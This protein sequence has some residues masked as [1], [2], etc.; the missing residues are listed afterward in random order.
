MPLALTP[1]D[2]R[3][4]ADALRAAEHSVKHYMDENYNQ[5]QHKI[6]RAEYDSLYEFCQTL[7]CLSNDATTAAVGLSLDAL[8]VPV[9]ELKGVIEEANQK[10]KTLTKI[11]SVMSCVSAL[12]NLATS[13][14]DRNPGAIVTSVNKLRHAIR[15]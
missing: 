13:I 3:T 5:D 4:V 7:L 2:A 15:A 9:V 14:I 6:S 11:S 1:D 12:V 8:A 10:I